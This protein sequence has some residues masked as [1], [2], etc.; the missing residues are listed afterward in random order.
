MT[1]VPCSWGKCGQGYRG[2]LSTC[3]YSPNIPTGKAQERAKSTEIRWK[4]ARFTSCHAVPPI[5]GPSQTFSPEK[6]LLKAF[7]FSFGIS[8]PC[9][10]NLRHSRGKGAAAATWVLSL[11]PHGIHHRVLRGLWMCPSKTLKTPSK[12]NPTLHCRS[13]ALL[14]STDSQYI[15]DLAAGHG[16]QI[17]TAHF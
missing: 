13:P 6:Q 14:Q 11:T 7:C 9:Y 1:S 8:F 4:A 16:H 10:P 5:T 17:G 15:S 3:H 12:S 2:W